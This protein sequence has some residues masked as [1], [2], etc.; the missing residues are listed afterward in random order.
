LKGCAGR[1]V[2]RS[3]L[4]LG[5]EMTIDTEVHLLGFNGKL[6]TALLFVAIVGA[7]VM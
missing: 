6:E 5:R 3:E 4:S 2:R 1:H 7:N